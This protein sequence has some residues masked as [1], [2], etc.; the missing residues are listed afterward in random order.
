MRRWLVSPLISPTDFSLSTGFGRRYVAPQRRCVAEGGGGKQRVDQLEHQSPVQEGFSLH[1]AW[2]R[3]VSMYV[4]GSVVA[5]MGGGREKIW[6]KCMSGT[7]GVLF[8]RRVR[9]P[10]SAGFCLPVE[11]VRGFVRPSS[12][13][14]W[15]MRS[16]SRRAN[17]FVR[18]PTRI[19]PY[20]GAPCLSVLPPVAGLPP[21]A[22]TM[23]L[24]HR[25]V[26]LRPINRYH[27]APAET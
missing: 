19:P 13:C 11:Y 4:A 26:L 14:T 2:W 6:C 5:S 17:R 27:C 18:S 25:V 22:V 3:A 8:A 1:P 21:V 15:K 10:P 7:F 23:T 24:W 9:R 20:P 12:T 16:I